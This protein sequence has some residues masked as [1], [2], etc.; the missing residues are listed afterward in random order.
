M[1]TYI[2]LLCLTV[3][4]SVQLHA[5]VVTEDVNFDFYQSITNNDF[6][7]NFNGITGITQ[8]QTNGITGG[9]LLLEDSID[10]G[11]DRGTYCTAYKPA[12]GDTAITGVC[13][14]Y[15]S[16]IVV[17]S[18][19]QRAM[20]IFM[21]PWADPNHYVIATISHQKK[22][23]LITYAWVNQFPPVNLLH[24]H[25]Y[26]YTLTTTFFPATFQVYIKA[27]V[28][29]LGLSGTAAPVLASSASHTITDN[30]LSIDTAIQVAISG[31]TYGGGIYLDNFHFHGRKGFSNCTNVTGI[32]NP[33]VP[34]VLNI[35]YSPVENTVHVIRNKS[36]AGEMILSIFNAEG[37]RVM[38]D[39]TSAA[40]AELNISSLP[41]GFY[42][43]QCKTA[44]ETKKFKVLLSK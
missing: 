11:N 9:C 24:Q 29:D 4:M 36:S 30:V 41:V 20:T 13:F 16:S 40:S 26:Q 42:I 7:N 33:V 37:K 28:F 21:H 8:I 25:W 31:A 12:A 19:L 44:N 43:A 6:T 39:K 32:A 5:Q 38:E 14:K 34:G 15:D 3:A 1:R 10:W 27:E 35:Y 17:P 23:E 22:I 18:A 2:T